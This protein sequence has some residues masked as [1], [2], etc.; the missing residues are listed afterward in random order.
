MANRIIDP[1]RVYTQQE[2]DILTEEWN[3]RDRSGYTFD[4]ALEDFSGGGVF[5]H[6][7]L[8]QTYTALSDAEIEQLKLQILASGRYAI[9]GEHQRLARLRRRAE[10][11]AAT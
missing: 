4:Q 9:T 11:L 8:R 3:S 1:N 2:L 10:K 5:S 6:A 7:Y